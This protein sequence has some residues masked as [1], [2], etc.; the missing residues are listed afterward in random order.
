MKYEPAAAPSVDALAAAYVRAAAAADSADSVT[1]AALDDAAD[2]AYNVYAA[3]AHAAGAHPID[4][5]VLYDGTAAARPDY[6]PPYVPTQYVMI[7]VNR[8]AFMAAL[9]T[10]AAASARVTGEYDSPSGNAECMDYVQL[11][12]VADAR[13]GTIAMFDG[14]D[15]GTVRAECPADTYSE[16]L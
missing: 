14:D 8:A 9:A 16:S 15:T 10:A 1:Y 11:S 13:G 5:A 4:A 3:A 12:V 2:A 6:P 7:R